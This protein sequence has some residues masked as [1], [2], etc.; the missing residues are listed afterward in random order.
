MIKI[1]NGQLEMEGTLNVLLADITTIYYKGLE[2]L[3]KQSGIT[4]KELRSTLEQGHQFS[5]LIESGMS[6]KEAT[7]IIHEEK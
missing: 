2:K 5:T 4:V 1:K 6:A 3:S 7:G